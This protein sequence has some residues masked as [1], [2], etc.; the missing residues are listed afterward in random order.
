MTKLLL[1]EDVR[2]LGRKGQVVTVKPGYAR[3]L[4]PK[5]WAFIATPYTLKLQERFQEEREKRAIVEKKESEEQSVIL[6][7]LTVKTLVKVDHDGHMYGSV[8]AADIAHLI[9][10]SAHTPIEKHAIAIKSPLR[11]LGEHKVTVKLKEGVQAIVTVIIEAEEDP[12][13][14]KMK[15]REA[16]LER[17][18]QREIEKQE[19]KKRKREKDRS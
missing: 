10:A 2:N 12:H 6:S 16:E 18:K 9:E 14:I 8:S 7:A 11:T 17:E 5:G 1:A 13:L 4:V 15:E 19:A 3:Y